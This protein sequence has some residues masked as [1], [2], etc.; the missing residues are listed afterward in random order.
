MF[1][2]IPNAFN[3]I[4]NRAVLGLPHRVAGKIG[5]MAVSAGS[6][7]Y[8]PFYRL[9]CQ[10]IIKDRFDSRERE[11]HIVKGLGEMI[12]GARNGRI[13]VETEDLRLIAEAVQ[14]GLNEVGYHEVFDPH[15]A[16]ILENL[17]PLTPESE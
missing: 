10:E 15:T 7:V 6:W 14:P 9:Q 3:D 12:I 4:E 16:L 1:K 8:P 17:A 2:S 13:L 11:E 5:G